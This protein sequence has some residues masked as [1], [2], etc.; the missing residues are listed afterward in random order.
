MIVSWSGLCRQPFA[1]P[2]RG[3]SITSQ[4]MGARRRPGLSLR[5]WTSARPI[6]DLLRA[7]R[8]RRRMS[9]LDLACEA[10]ISTRHLSFLETGRAQPSRDMV[11][12]LAE[13]L[14][15]P[16]RDRNVLLV[17]AGFAP[18]FPERPLEDPR[19]DRRAQPSISCSP[20]H[21][22]YPA[23]AVDRHWTLVAA[24]AR[25]AAPD[26]RRRRQVAAAPRQRAAP[27]P[28]SGGA[29]AAH[30]QSCAMARAPARAPAPADRS[31]RRPRACRPAGGA[32]QAIQRP[33]SRGRPR[34]G[35]GRQ[36]SAGVVVP[37]QARSPTARPVLLQHHH[38]VRHAARHHAVG[39][40]AR[41]LLSGRC[42]HRRG[43]A[44]PRQPTAPTGW[45]RQASPCTARP[46]AY[47]QAAATA[48]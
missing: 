34:T 22:P 31:S 48:E 37:L 30:R 47:V 43:A 19:C 8:Q 18:V 10:E 7:W 23:L 21:E 45:L 17:S 27:E 28:A 6:G 11:L 42:R 32:A 40:G 33:P 12:H 13:R 4:V 9:Q 3:K 36:T 41:S 14:E 20:G 2:R 46:W 39:A 38:G 26:R 44:P 16:L 35:F 24:N 5:P 25:P 1:D 15:I 29:G